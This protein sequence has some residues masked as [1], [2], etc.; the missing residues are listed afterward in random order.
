MGTISSIG[1]G[2]LQIRIGK[3]EQRRADGN[4][5]AHLAGLFDLVQLVGHGG[6][7]ATGQQYGGDGGAGEIG[8]GVH[9]SLLVVMLVMVV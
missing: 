5:H 4:R 3:A 2:G 8:L 6:M 7:G 9:V 1:A